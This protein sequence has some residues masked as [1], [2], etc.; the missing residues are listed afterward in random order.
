[1]IIAGSSEMLLVLKDPRGDTN[2]STRPFFPCTYYL[3]PMFFVFCFLRL[4]IYVCLCVSTLCPS[5]D[6]LIYL[7]P[8]LPYSHVPS[9]VRFSVS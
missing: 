4:F 5:V 2:H 6:F 3:L 8:Y 7:L 1:M 9:I